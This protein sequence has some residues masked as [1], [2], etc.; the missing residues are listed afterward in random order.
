M[1][2]RRATDDEVDTWQTEGWVLLDG[3]VGSDEIDVV[4]DGRLRDVSDERGLS[5]GSGR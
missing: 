3:I 2:S 5:R 1:V 4:L